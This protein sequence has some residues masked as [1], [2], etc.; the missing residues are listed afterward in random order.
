MQ[1]LPT[2]YHYHRNLERILE[3][4]YYSHIFVRLFVLSCM[5]VEKPS[6]IRDDWAVFLN[7]LLAEVS[8]NG[9]S[10]AGGGGSEGEKTGIPGSHPMEAPDQS[11]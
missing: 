8:K 9:R 5:S 2:R 6:K 3:S 10:G 11:Q 1:T 4:I 7:S